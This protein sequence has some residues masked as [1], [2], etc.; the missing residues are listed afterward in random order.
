MSIPP[1]QRRSPSPVTLPPWQPLMPPNPAGEI[2]CGRLVPAPIGDVAMGWRDE[3]A[4]LDS[5]GRFLRMAEKG[6]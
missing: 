2:L 3:Y 1:K 5:R 6:D 4:W